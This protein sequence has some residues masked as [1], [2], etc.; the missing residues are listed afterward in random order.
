M[1]HPTDH[2]LD[3]SIAGML[4]VGV[5]L[6]ALVVLAGGVLSLRHRPAAVPDFA[7]FHPA[8]PSLQTLPGI[9]EGTL[10]LQAEAMIQFGLVLLIATPVARVVF[11]VFGFARQRDKLYTAIS[12]AVLLILIYSLTKGAH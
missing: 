12:L 11:C 9:V 1:R 6:A 7:H 8:G 5:T 2:E 10:H 3:L 4:R